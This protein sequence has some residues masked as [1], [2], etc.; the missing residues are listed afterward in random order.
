[1]RELGEFGE[2]YGIVI[3]LEVHGT[4][5]SLLPNIRKILDVADHKNVGACWNS[6]QSDLEGDGFDYNFDL[7]KGKIFSVHMRDLYL[8]EYPF[9]KLLTRLNESG[10]SGYCLAEI[11]P[12]P[13]RFAS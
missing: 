9:R 7:V 6:N 13:I 5:T 2:N 12:A 3:R 4:S 11:P 1:M 8:D 10:F